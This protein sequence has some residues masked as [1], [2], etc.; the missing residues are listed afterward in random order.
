[1]RFGIGVAAFLLT[2]FC[3]V[4][5]AQAA[6]SDALSHLLE[7]RSCL[8]CDLKNA[9]LQNTDLRA[10]NL[11]GADLSGANLSGANL[12]AANLQQAN[13]SKADL[14]DSTLFGVN[15]FSTNLR[16]AIVKGVRF[17]SARFCHTTLPDGEIF[18]QDC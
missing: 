18:D 6:N 10:V 11:R 1:M 13:L 8:G 16:Q 15:L 17:G 7:S 2:L 9:D 14:T 12:M 4:L 3:F 5:P